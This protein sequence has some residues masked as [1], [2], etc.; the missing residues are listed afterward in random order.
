MRK[1]NAGY[2][3]IPRCPYHLFDMVKGNM[4]KTD[5]ILD[6][7][8]WISYQDKTDKVIEFKKTFKLIGEI[9]AAKLYIC[10]L[11]FFDAEINEKKISADYFKPLVTDYS[12]RDL[13]AERQ[14]VNGVKKRINLCRYDVTKFLMRG[15][16][17]LKATVANGYYQNDDR[18]EEPFIAIYGEKKLIFDLR[19]D[20]ADGSKEKILSNCETLVRQTNSSCGLYIGQRIDFSAANGEWIPSSLTA[21]PDGEFFLSDCPCD[22]I[23]HVLKPVEKTTK[24]E[25]LVLDFGENHSGGLAFKIKG[26]AGQKITVGHAETLYENGELNYET[27]RYE[28]FDSKSGKLLRRIDQ[29]S[30]YVLSGN[31]DKIEPTFN[32]FCYRYVEIIG[33]KKAEISDIGSYYIH[34]DVKRNE[35][36]CSEKIFEEIVEKTCRTIYNNMHSGLITD[37]PHREKRPYTGDGGIIAE[38]FMYLVDGEKFLS[39]WLDD[40]LASQ[41]E[42]GYVPNTAPHL[43]GGGGYAWGN[44]IATIPEVLYNHTGDKIYLKKS[45]PYIKKWTEYLES[46]YKNCEV[47]PPEGQKWALGDWLAP[48]ITEFNISLM[49]LLTF[50]RAVNIAERFAGILGE[51]AKSYKFLKK[52]IVTDIN[53]KHFNNVEIRYDKGIQGENILPLQF[54]IVPERYRDELRKKIRKRYAEDLNFH[55]DTGIISTPFLIDCLTDNG[56]KDVA[57]KIITARDYPS[58]QYMLEGETTLS[59]HWSKRWP[60]YYLNGTDDIVKGGGHLSHCHPMFGSVCAWLY[61]RVAGLDLSKVCDGII[62][63]EPIFIDKLDCSS[64]SVITR[65]GKTGIKWNKVPLFNAEIEVPEGL[66]GELRLTTNFCVLVENEERI[67][68]NRTKENG[69]I[70][71]KLNSGK[72]NVKFLSEE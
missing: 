58:Y 43:G 56:M 44:A 16:N 11:G 54:N 57:F 67:Q 68:I 10:G 14:I 40:I 72:W 71:I 15:E 70:R 19:V 51:D 28:E 66:I 64:A 37:C 32:W 20:F 62:V 25:K 18:P 38:S 6:G 22:R 4:K 36:N 24:G 39:K 46:R 45:L 50:Y 41:A 7:A 61:K 31:V 27:S 42:N 69:K 17:T 48:A 60:D 13:K 3:S 23:E 49:N 53:E 59:E 5:I 34:A 55:L 21:V 29:I 30:E 2:G 47:L 52:R 65:Y 35:F 12:I 9:S 1:G 8:K 26:V 63:F 33:L